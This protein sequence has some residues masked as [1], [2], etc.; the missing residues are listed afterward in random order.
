M[1]Q[2]AQEGR[3]FP[4]HTKAS[5]ESRHS[6]SNRPSGVEKDGGTK[7]QDSAVMNQSIAQDVWIGHPVC[8]K[9]RLNTKT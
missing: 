2:F 7:E 4:T 3:C 6:N 5:F 9:V 8:L 1:N